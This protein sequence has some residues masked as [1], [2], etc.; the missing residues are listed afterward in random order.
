MTRLGVYGGTFDPVHIGHVLVAADVRHAL[1]LDRLLMVV[2]H[3]PWQKS[4]RVVA[5]AEDRFALVAAAVEDLDGVEASRIEID[6]GGPSY[7]ADTIAELA[8]A[9][10][11]A[12]LFVVV[13]ADVS[14]DLHTWKRVAVIRDLATL[15]VVNRGGAPPPAHPEGWRVLDV[16]IPSL[17]VSSTEIRDRLAAGRPVEALMPAAA[18]RLLRE[19]ALYPVP[20]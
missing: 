8:E 16:D 9:D 19:R 4:N 11:T 15:V 10:P 6:R 17:E 5:S 2:A 7:T 3:D 1:A 13:G 12:E 14:D 18:I 20:G